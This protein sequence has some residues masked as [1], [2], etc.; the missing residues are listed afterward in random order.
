MPVLAV[1]PIRS[2]TRGKERLSAALDPRIRTQVGMAMALRTVTAAESA[3]MLPTVVTGDKEVASWAVG[4][5]IPVV[6]EQGAG[7]NH[8]AQAGVDRALESGLQW[9]VLHSDLP[10]VTAPDLAEVS[11][12]IQTGAAML[13]PSADGGTTALSAPELIE[14]RYGRGSAHRHLSQLSDPVIVVR[15]GLLL[16]LD[17]IADLHAAS[18]HPEGEWLRD[19]IS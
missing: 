2:F 18:A 6:A 1:V 8:A 4:L 11:A 16:D 15:T 13:A 9:V 3:S 19:L 14:F 10:L 12:A 17:S 5:G 7:L